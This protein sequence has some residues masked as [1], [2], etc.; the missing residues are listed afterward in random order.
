MISS[1]LLQ[2]VPLNATTAH[3][4]HTGLLNPRLP[5]PHVKVTTLTPTSADRTSYLLS[6]DEPKKNLAFYF[7]VKVKTLCITQHSES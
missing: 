4:Y 3:F 5:L 6:K 7:A 1:V 2:S